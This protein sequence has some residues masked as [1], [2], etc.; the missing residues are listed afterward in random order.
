M[1]HRHAGR[2]AQDDGDDGAGAHALVE[3]VGG[4]LDPHRD[5]RVGHLDPGA[6][7]SRRAR[8]VARPVL[9]RGRQGGLPDHRGA[10]EQKL[11]DAQLRGGFARPERHG[12]GEILAPEQVPV[13]R[14]R[15]RDVQRRGGILRAGQREGHAV[16]PRGERLVVRGD[17]DHRRRRPRHRHRVVPGRAVLGRD[18]HG[19]R[20]H[21]HR[22]RHLESVLRLVR[23]VDRDAVRVQIVDRRAGVALRRR[24]GHLV[25]G[26]HHRR[27]VGRRARHEG[28]QVRTAA[29]HRQIAQRRVGRGGACGERDGVVRTRHVERGTARG[30]SEPTKSAFTITLDTTASDAPR[31]IKRPDPQPQ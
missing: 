21:A 28:H 9:H 14:Q 30:N 26:A 25:D 15:D 13:L 17:G 31:P 10:L 3:R 5:G 1:G 23:V 20:V 19:D 8:H 29:G 4:L 6:C 16:E 2:G 22:E 11:L 7:R 18:P 27:R 12:M 24:H